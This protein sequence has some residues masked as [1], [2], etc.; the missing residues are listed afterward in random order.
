[1]SFAHRVVLWVMQRRGYLVGLNERQ[2]FF[3]RYCFVGK[4]TSVLQI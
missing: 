3:T 4:P 1:M 2:N